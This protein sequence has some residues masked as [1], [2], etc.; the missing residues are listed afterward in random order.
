MS[1]SH[2]TSLVGVF[3]APTP[4]F[5]LNPELSNTSSISGIADTSPTLASDNPAETFANLIES[6]NDT[7]PNNSLKFF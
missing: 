5:S 1:P 4:N 2:L 7:F 3:L 6:S